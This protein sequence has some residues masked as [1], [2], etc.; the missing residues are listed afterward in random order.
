M[1][2]PILGNHPPFSSCVAVSRADPVTAILRHGCLKASS[3]SV[4]HSVPISPLHFLGQLF[5]HEPKMV[6]HLVM[7]IRLSYLCW[8]KDYHKLQQLSRKQ[9]FWLTQVRLFMSYLNTCTL[10]AVFK[11]DNKSIGDMCEEGKP[12]ISLA[13]LPKEKIWKNRRKRYP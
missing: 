12:K 8:C 3:Q 13:L 4:Q 7:I 5:F 10:N 9:L 6:H 11:W 1:I 2:I